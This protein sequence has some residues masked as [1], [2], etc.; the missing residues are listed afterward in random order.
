MNRY[1]PGKA[2]GYTKMDANENNNAMPVSVEIKEMNRYP[3]TDSVQLKKALSSYLSVGTDQL[4]CGNGSS[5]MIELLLK[6][7]INPGDKVMTFDPSFV[8]YK[9]FTELYNGTFVPVP[10]K[11]YVMDMNIMIQM[12]EVENP[13]LIFICNPN[14][15]TGYLISKVEIERL[16]KNVNCIV[17]V[18]EAYIE[19]TEGSMMNRLG[20]YDNLVILRTFS[21]AWGL[22]GARLGYMVANPVITD[23]INCVKS[24]YNL[25]K[26]SQYIGVKALE[27]SKPLDDYVTHVIKERERVSKAMT[28][29][30]LMV[31]QSSA[32]FVF[33]RSKKPL[34]DAL[35]SYGILIRTFKNG[36]YRVT[37]GTRT[38]N[39][40]FLNA[41]VE[42]L[43]TRDEVIYDAKY[44]S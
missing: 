22:A 34:Y 8:M 26:L 17:V 16:L 31:Y 20:D 12:A 11:D 32:N 24:P 44:T 25:N 28:A 2:E 19:F 6:A 10:C 37:L 5:E 35:K 42:I 1:I 29:F 43:N 23:Y 4:T 13:K 15:P 3:D 40:N 38:E 14:N 36:C 30:G 33:F 7:F 18:D 9:N 21:K 41:L 39:T 27:N